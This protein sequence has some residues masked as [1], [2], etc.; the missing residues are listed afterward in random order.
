MKPAYGGEQMHEFDRAIARG[1]AEAG[2]T[3][4]QLDT[5]DTAAADQHL[6]GKGVADE[7]WRN[8]AAD[9]V[10]ADFSDGIA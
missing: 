2:V 3:E 1:V 5:A 7:V 9:T 10:L 4:H 6:R 8:R